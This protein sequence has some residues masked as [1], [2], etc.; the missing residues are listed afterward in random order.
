MDLEIGEKIFRTKSIKR[1]EGQQ[2]NT[3]FT[4]KFSNTLWHR[5]WP[6]LASP[7]SGGQ[8]ACYICRDKFSSHIYLDSLTSLQSWPSFSVF[9]FL[10]YWILISYSGVYT[11]ALCFVS[12]SWFSF[13]GL[14]TLDGAP[15]LLL[16]APQEV[17]LS[18]QIVFIVAFL[19]FSLSTRL[20]FS[21][22]YNNPDL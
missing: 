22:L 18:L 19:H 7:A 20:P 3:A 15:P 1:V 4:Q 5:A 14:W 13:S 11:V 9:H 8:G 16:F 6:Q 17:W 21:W 2:N 12:G 10:V